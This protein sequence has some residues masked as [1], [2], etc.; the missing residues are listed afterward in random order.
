M[1]IVQNSYNNEQKH[2]FMRGIRTAGVAVLFPI[3]SVVASAV[4]LFL[5]SLIGVGRGVVWEMAGIIAFMS[6][7]TL[8]DTLVWYRD[9]QTV[10]GD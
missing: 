2:Q 9:R 7:L 6:V 4:V 8:L 1:T 5:L 10:G 3:I